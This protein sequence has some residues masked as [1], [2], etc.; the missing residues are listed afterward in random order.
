[1][2]IVLY[3]GRLH[4][5]ATLPLTN[6]A[7]LANI[8][9][10]RNLQ[11]EEQ[12][13]VVCNL[14]GE[15]NTENI[16]W[17]HVCRALCYK[18]ETASV[19]STEITVCKWLQ[20]DKEG[21]SSDRH[22]VSMK[23]TQTVIFKYGPILQQCSSMIHFNIIPISTSRV[24]NKSLPF[25]FLEKILYFVVVSPRAVGSE[26]ESVGILRGVGVGENVPTPTPTSV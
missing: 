12:I 21:R 9:N 4:G 25:G 17:R 1:M 3:C 6:T 13:P 8:N 19:P 10:W 15:K 2:Y 18:T 16:A 22:P 14:Y 7:I 23:P 5:H 11:K 20:G 24:S 26:S